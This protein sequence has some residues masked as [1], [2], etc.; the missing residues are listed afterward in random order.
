MNLQDL[1]FLFGVFALV[2]IIA[3]AWL[4]FWLPHAMHERLSLL[5]ATGAPGERGGRWKLA[6][7][8]WLVRASRWL[9]SQRSGAENGV[10][11]GADSAA[12]T[13]RAE[14]PAR[15]Q[16][17]LASLLVQAGWRSTTAPV[18]FHLGRAAL[19]L[20][21]PVVLMLALWAMDRMPAGYHRMLLVVTAA[22]AG[23]VLPWWGLRHAVQRRQQT[24]FRAFPDALDLMRVCVQAGLGLDAAIERVARE[25]VLA[26]APL[27][28]ELGLTVLE[29]RAGVSR[30][31]PCAT[32]LRAW[33]WPRSMPW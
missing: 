31:T 5:R 14:G 20:L 19:A 15:A 10:A 6:V 28:E 3:F 33:V 8:T 16:D 25:V 11:S 12:A 13:A 22:L 21:L 29:L 4:Q 17:E 1:L 24:L 30:G 26:S 27:S 23:H 7:S 18:V 32:W 9:T 2:S